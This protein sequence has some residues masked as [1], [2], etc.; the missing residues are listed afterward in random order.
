M[1]KGLSFIRRAVKDFELARRYSN[2]R[3][4]LTASTLYRMATEKALKALIV[5]KKNS[6]LPKNATIEYLAMQ[7]NL[8]ENLYDEITNMPDEMTEML[9]EEGLQEYDD[10]E[11]SHLA[12]RSEYRGALSKRESVRKLLDYARATTTL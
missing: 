11:H 5:R 10:G 8:P 9:E 6:R 1:R 2:S 4:Y 12:V 7:A 3:E